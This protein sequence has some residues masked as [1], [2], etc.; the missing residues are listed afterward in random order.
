MFIC[1]IFPPKSF[2][3]RK[4]KYSTYKINMRVNIIRGSTRSTYVC[5]NYMNNQYDRDCYEIMMDFGVI[6]LDIGTGSYLINT[7][8]I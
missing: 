7:K 1:K 6:W 8:I 5:R 4:Q 2:L 3:G